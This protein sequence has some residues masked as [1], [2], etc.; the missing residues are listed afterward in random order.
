MRTGVILATHNN[1]LFLRNCLLQIER[2]TCLPAAVAIHENGQAESARGYKMVREVIKALED[3]SVQFI[4]DLSPMGL[5]RPFFQYLPLKRL[6]DSGM[7]THYTKMD[8]DD[9]FYADHL[10]RLE[11]IGNRHDWVGLKRADIAILN[12]AQYTYHREVDFGLFNPLGGPSDTFLY[13]HRVATEYL[14]DMMSRAGTNEADDWILHKYTLP[15]FKGVVFDQST[16]MCY[17]SHGRNDST[18]HWVSQAPEELR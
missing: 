9:V 2:Q 11:D 3:R 8:H 1:P 18:R 15:K 13:N 10:E 4:Y 14:Q 6:L 7:C 17:I 5:S 16:T 12:A